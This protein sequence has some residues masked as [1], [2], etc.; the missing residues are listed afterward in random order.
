VLVSS[1]ILTTAF[2]WGA[3][4]RTFGHWPFGFSILGELRVLLG[5]SWRY[6]ALAIATFVYS[7]FQIPLIAHFL[8]SEQTGLYRSAFAMAAAIELL[9]NS[10]NALLLPR[11]VAWRTQGVE[12]LWRRQGKLFMIFLG[13]GATATLLLMLAAP[14]VYRV[15]LGPAFVRA[16]PIFRLL[17][18][19]RLIVFVG[20]IYAFGLAALNMDRAFLAATI[21]GA[22][23]SLV[24]NVVLL[25]HAGLVGAAL[26]SILSESLVAGFCFVALRRHVRAASRPLPA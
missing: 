5:E 7:T 22:V 25:P 13:I 14:F 12:V 16:V 8:G 15:L 18:L 3:N 10:V 21:L 2:S 20:Q 11:L 1:G 4:R 17:L 26:V 24:M 23:V 6:W 9:Y 19:G